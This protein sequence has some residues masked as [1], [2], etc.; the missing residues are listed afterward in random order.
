MNI[1]EKLLELGIYVPE[2]AHRY[3]A[4]KGCLI[5]LAAEGEEGAAIFQM[6]VTREQYEG[7]MAAGLLGDRGWHVAHA[8]AAPATS[9]SSQC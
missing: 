7:M 1:R 3:R 2:A 4:G 8:Y 5:W 6:P 9:N